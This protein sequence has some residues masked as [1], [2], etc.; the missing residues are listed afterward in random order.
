VLRSLI[1]GTDGVKEAQENSTQ[2]ADVNVIGRLAVWIQESTKASRK[3]WIDFPYEFRE[4]CPAKATALGM[5][6][7][8]ARSKA[9][10]IAY[11]CKKPRYN[12]IPDTEEP[13]IAGVFS[14]VYSL[15]LQLF[16]FRPQPDGFHTGQDELSEVLGS[17][18]SF[19]AALKLLDSLLAN[20]PTVRYCIIHGLNDLEIGDGLDGCKAVLEVLFSHARHAKHPFSLLFTTAGQSRALYAVMDRKDR[21]SSDASTTAV[22]K[23]GLNL[24]IVQV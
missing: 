17:E 14:L 5:I 10:F 19:R 6:S 1:Y 7:I 2:L 21:A 4:D 11:I 24:N 9:P 18:H 23:R 22:A 12:Q 3:L 15:I 16:G 8:T 13:E 20:T